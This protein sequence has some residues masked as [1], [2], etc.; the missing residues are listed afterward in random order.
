[1]WAFLRGE[2]LHRL[3]AWTAIDRE[4]FLKRRA[5]YLIYK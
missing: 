2:P 5:S 4:N 3:I 1:M